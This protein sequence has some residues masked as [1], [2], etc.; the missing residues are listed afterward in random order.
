MRKLLL[1]IFLVGGIVIASAQV[2]KAS[3]PVCAYCGVDL[4]TGVSH[5]SNCRYYK[6]EQET[7]DKGE[8]WAPNFNSIEYKYGHGVMCEQCERTNGH[9]SDCLIGKTQGYIRDYWAKSKTPESY[10]F[11]IKTYEDNILKTL[12]A[13][14]NQYIITNKKSNLYNKNYKKIGTISSGY[15]LELTKISNLTSKNKYLLI[16]LPAATDRCLL[17]PLVKNVILVTFSVIFSCFK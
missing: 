3:K 9:D 13:N 10:K 8:S 1:S 7:E 15:Y 14:Y 4:T 17:S 5:K 12:K 6:K 2:P 11:L 16:T